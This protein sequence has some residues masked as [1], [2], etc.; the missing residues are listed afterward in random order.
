MLFP[1]SGLSW[2]GKNGET[3]ANE[4]HPRPAN[5]FQ[6][7]RI[8]DCKP[9]HNVIPNTIWLVSSL[10]LILCETSKCKRGEKRKAVCY[11]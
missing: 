10:L 9:I 3:S 6:N 7:P 4:V 11:K 1:V 8:C 2:I 5:W